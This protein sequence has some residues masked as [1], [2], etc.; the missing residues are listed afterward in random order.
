MIKVSLAPS[1]R[2]MRRLSMGVALSAGIMM[3]ALTPAEAAKT[4]PY[5]KAA[6][7][8]IGRLREAVQL[9]FPRPLP[10]VTV[11]VASSDLPFAIK[12]F[13]AAE[14]ITHVHGVSD[15]RD[16]DFARRWGVAIADGALIV[17]TF[18]NPCK[19][20]EFFEALDEVIRADMD[21]RRKARVA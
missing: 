4:G 21:E 13:C 15:V 3:L 20:G 5:A 14:G 8:D 1:A 9:A 12:R 18:A 7:A 6:L 10:G 19:P 2:L 11:L 17:G 16:R